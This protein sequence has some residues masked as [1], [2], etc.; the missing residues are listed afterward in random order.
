MDGKVVIVT[1]AFG[2]L[3]AAVARAFAAA[4]ASVALVDRVDAPPAELAGALQGKALFLG[5][6]DLTEPAGARS[7]VDAAID[8]FGH[9]DVV[10]NVAGGFRWELVADGDPATWSTQP[11]RQRGRSSTRRASSTSTAAS[12]SRPGRS[13]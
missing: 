13:R 12:R 5:G 7:A 2:V 6:V 1:G 9:L 11:A 10:A 3:G 8:R 4:G